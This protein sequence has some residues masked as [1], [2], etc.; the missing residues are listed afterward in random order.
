M[1]LTMQLIQL[2]AGLLSLTMTDGPISLILPCT[3][4]PS[5]RAV[6]RERGYRTGSDASKNFMFSKKKVN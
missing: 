1:D 6:K 3:T 2:A 5:G 4:F